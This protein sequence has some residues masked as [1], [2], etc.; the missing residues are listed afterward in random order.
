[1]VVG[2]KVDEEEP[3]ELVAGAGEARGEDGVD[4]DARD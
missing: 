4:E 1:M 2:E 3:V